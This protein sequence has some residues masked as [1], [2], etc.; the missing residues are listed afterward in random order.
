MFQL[1]LQFSP[2]KCFAALLQSRGNCELPALLWLHGLP[3]RVDKRWNCSFRAAGC[4]PTGASCQPGPGERSSLLMYKTA[5]AKP[6]LS[7]SWDFARHS[8]HLPKPARFIRQY[9]CYWSERH[10]PISVTIK[11]HVFCIFPTLT[12]SHG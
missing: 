7:S 2:S 10:S 5:G 12:C 6:R 9:F 4:I 3:H 8:P 1:K 11:N